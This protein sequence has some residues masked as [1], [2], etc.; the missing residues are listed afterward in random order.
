VPRFRAVVAY[1]GAPFYGFQRH[2]DGKPTVQAALESALAKLNG[3]PV[4]V[5]GAGR[6][7]RGVHASGNV[8]AFDLEWNHGEQTL[9]RALNATLPTEIAIQHLESTAPTFHPRFD[10]ISRVYRY[11]CFEAAYRNPLYALNSWHV[12]ANHDVARM[13]EAAALIHGEHDFATFGN[14]TQGD[15][16]TRYVIHSAWMIER[17]A[18]AQ[19]ARMLVY[20]VEANGFLHHMVRTLVGALIDVGS[21]KWSVAQFMDALQAADRGRAQHMAPPQ[22]LVLVEV[23]YPAVMPGAP[24]SA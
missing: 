16:T 24:G 18:S 17:I 8:V 23:K 10:A 5:L 13:N 11:T 9:I 19:P 14:P 2:A 22:G 21:G 15:N 4:R 7:D 20:T 6:T 1:D 12:W 3:R